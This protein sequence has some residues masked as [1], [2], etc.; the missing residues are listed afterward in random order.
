MKTLKQKDKYYIEK[1]PRYYEGFD[2]NWLNFNIFIKVAS[3]NKIIACIKEL[4]CSKLYKWF[5]LHD[6]H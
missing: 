1:L 4:L 2:K 6:K 3:K 5:I